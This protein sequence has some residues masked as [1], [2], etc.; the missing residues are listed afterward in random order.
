VLLVIRPIMGVTMVYYGWPKVRDPK[1]NATDFEA[2]GV[3][4]GMFWGTL[5]LEFGGG[6]AILLGLY[7]WVAA[8]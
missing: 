2:K 4:P 8:A 6:L 7:A 3:K 1:K 5:I